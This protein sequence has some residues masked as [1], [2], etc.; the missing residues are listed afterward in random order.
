VD[1]NDATQLLETAVCPQQ[2][3]TDF[4][5]KKTGCPQIEGQE[6]PSM[7]PIAL[8]PGGKLAGQE[9]KLAAGIGKDCAGLL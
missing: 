6:S 7:W 1:D 5:K 8:T 3:S 9:E 2:T 4:E